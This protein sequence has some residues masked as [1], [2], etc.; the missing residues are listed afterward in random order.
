MTFLNFKKIQPRGD[1]VIWVILLFLL[2]LSILEV[3]SSIGKF[4]YDKAS[5]NT[6][7]LL[8]KHLLIIAA[9]VSVIIVL[10]NVKY[11]YFSILSKFGY[12]ISIPLLLFTFVVGFTSS[13]AAG[14]WLEVPI[15]GQF[16]PSE[17]VKFI[18]IIYMARLITLKRNEIKEFATF[19]KLLI[20]PLLIAG[21]I[22][23]ENFSTAI[24]LF[25]VCFVLLFIGGTKLRYW[26]GF[27]G[28]GL[29]A[30]VVF[31]FAISAL[32]LDFARSGTWSKRIEEYIGRDKEALTQ[33]NIAKMAI[34]S[35]GVVGKMP[36]NTVQGRLLSESHN[37]FIYAV[38]IEELGLMGGIIVLLL[39]LMFFFRCMWIAIKAE[40]L[41]AAL[42]AVGLGLM[43]TVQAFVNMG[44]AVNLFPVTGQTLPFISYGGTSFLF[45]S[46]AVGII[47][48]ISADIQKK[49]AKKK[50]ESETAALEE[51]SEKTEETSAGE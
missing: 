41:F 48:S 10:S 30:L 40:G 13:K 5:G 9:S 22:F 34:A 4:A 43:L 49:D 19:R 25:F 35:G 16:Q 17:M 2:L 12:Y 28:M 8:F 26:F 3:Y 46:I 31:F 1:K 11:I 39:Y 38:I 37:D 23:P 36:G 20:P 51:N 21:L 27:A 32:D 42:T 47:L 7:K 45:S 15:I 33:A 29:L 6:T 24:L 44:V 50:E 18:M 14:R